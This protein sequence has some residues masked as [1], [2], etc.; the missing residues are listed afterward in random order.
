MPEMRLLLFGDGAL[1]SPAHIQTQLVQS[2]G[3]PYLCL[4]IQRAN[5]ALKQEVALLSP[6]ERRSIPPF[7]TIDE[8]SERLTS[9]KPHAGVQNALLVISQI[10]HYI[11]YADPKFNETIN[12]LTLIDM[13]TISVA[14]LNRRLSHVLLDFLRVC[15]LQ[16]LWHCHPPYPP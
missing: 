8:L 3:D 7:I 15:W 11:E 13:S 12:I 9:S 5:E 1:L 4:F 6:L 2:R 14:R 10:I 16:L